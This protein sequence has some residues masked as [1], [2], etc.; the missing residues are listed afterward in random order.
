MIDARI[1]VDADKARLAEI[2]VG[3]VGQTHM[4]LVGECMVTA[5]ETRTV[6]VEKH[7]KLGAARRELA[8]AVNAGMRIHNFWCAIDSDNV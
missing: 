1:G 3:N 7:V 6:R 4:R 2:D 5:A 8:P